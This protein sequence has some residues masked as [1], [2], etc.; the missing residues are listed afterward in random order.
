MPTQIIQTEQDTIKK[1]K[2]STL[3]ILSYSPPIHRCKINK[4]IF[5]S[6]LKINQRELRESLQ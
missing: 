2:Y 3:M 4:L 1:N 6:S 5:T